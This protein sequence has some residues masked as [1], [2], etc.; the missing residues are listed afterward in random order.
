MDEQAKAHLAIFAIACYRWHRPGELLNFILFM[1]VP[2]NFTLFMNVPQ[3]RV[4]DTLSGSFVNSA[5]GNSVISSTIKKK[6]LLNHY[7][8]NPNWLLI[9]M[10]LGLFIITSWRAASSCRARK[11]RGG[12][13]LLTLQMLPRL[14]FCNVTVALGLVV[15]SVWWQSSRT[16]CAALGSLLPPTSQYS[17]AR[18]HPKCNTSQSLQGSAIFRDTSTVLSA[19]LL[20][21]SP[22]QPTACCCRNNYKYCPCFWNEF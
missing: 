14:A 2:L 9:A 18:T 22:L 6:L 13:D 21:L 17:D 15:A 19:T 20:D 7:V 16:E 12:D 10:R 5:T 11:R 4:G 1:N 3:M 8:L